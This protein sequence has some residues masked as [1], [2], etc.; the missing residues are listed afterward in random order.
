MPKLVIKEVLGDTQTTKCI[1]WCIFRENSTTATAVL[2]FWWKK[3]LKQS[4][5][6][7]VVYVPIIW[8]LVLVT[9]SKTLLSLKLFSND[10]INTNMINCHNPNKEDHWFSVSS[11]FIKGDISAILITLDS[12]FIIDIIS[13]I[14]F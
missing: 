3:N 5:R 10:Q 8:R 13:T 9:L 4:Y 1:S 6:Q 11:H 12:H 14:I 2:L 7:L